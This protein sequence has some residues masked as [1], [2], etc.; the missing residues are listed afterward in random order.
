MEMK[1]HSRGPQIL[2]ALYEHGPM[3]IRGLQKILSPRMDKR[4]LRL[5]VKRLHGGGV[6]GG[7]PRHLPPNRNHLQL[8]RMTAGYWP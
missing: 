2:R 3:S 5:A 8:S 7:P 6:T 1:A 4:R